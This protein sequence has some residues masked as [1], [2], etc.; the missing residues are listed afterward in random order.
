MTNKLFICMYLWVMSC[1]VP[2]SMNYELFIYVPQWVQSWL[3]SIKWRRTRIRVFAVLVNNPSTAILQRIYVVAFT[4]TSSLWR[5]HMHGDV[6]TCTVTSAHTRWRH[7][8]HSRSSNRASDV[9]TCTGKSTYARGRRHIHG[10]VI[11]CM[12]TSTHTWWLHHM[13]GGLI[14]CTGKI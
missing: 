9:I 7:H 4:N 1:Y 3:V 5:H 11:T 6:I 14:T 10:D 2:A 8:M 12:G 13:H